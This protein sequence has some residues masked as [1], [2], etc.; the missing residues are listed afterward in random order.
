M[1]KKLTVHSGK[2]PVYDIIIEDSYDKLGFEMS[3]LST[4]NRKLCIVTESTVGPIYA[5]EIKAILKPVSKAVVV[6]TFQAGESNKNLDVVKRLYEFLI[7][8]HFERNDMLIALGGGVVGDLTGFTAATYLRGIDFVQLPTS[9]LSQVDSS[10]GGKTG[11]DFEAY[12]NMVGA[13]Y[14]PRLVFSN[15]SALRTL[16]RKQYLSGMGEVIK[17]GLI[18]DKE[19]YGWLKNNVCEVK[20]YDK[21]ALE[22][23]VYTSCDIKRRVVENDFKEKGERALLNFGHTLGHAIEKLM[24]FSM[25]HGECVSLGMVAAGYISLEKGYIASEEYEDIVNTLKLYELPVSENEFSIPEVIAATKCDKKMHSEII[26]FVVIKKIG[27]A[28]INRQVTDD[29]MKAS[30]EALKEQA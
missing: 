22:H 8:N 29:L 6:F 3:K 15:I 17:A 25:L 9:L 20:Q 28:V 12:K 2:T 13:F 18:K 10:V 4:E 21:N 30:L 19:F 26:N 11:V 16:T 5:E 1:S 24:N 23:L 14:Q 7:V 27:N